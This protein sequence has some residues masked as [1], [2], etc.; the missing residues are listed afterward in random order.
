MRKNLRVGLE[1]VSRH[2]CSET[3]SI[4]P[5][6][7]FPF[8]INFL[9]TQDSFCSR[10]LQQQ[11]TAQT[12]SQRLESSICQWTESNF[13]DV[14]HLSLQLLF[15]KLWQ[16]KW[17]SSGF[18]WKGW[19][20][21]S[22]N[23]SKYVFFFFNNLRMYLITWSIIYIIWSSSVQWVL[24]NLQGYATFPQFSFRI[25]LLPLKDLLCLFTVSFYTHLRSR[26]PQIC[27]H[28]CSFAFSGHFM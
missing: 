14:T 6:C 21:I 28:L 16:I 4:L 23:N 15:L 8:L 17:A 10:E 5:L 18:K 7:T 24:V 27:I 13:N 11:E 9:V 22:E 12:S 20:I 3:G 1:V 2:Q 25:F 19:N 26:E